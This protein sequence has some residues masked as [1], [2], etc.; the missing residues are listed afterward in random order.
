MDVLARASGELA[1]AIATYPR[2]KDVDDGFQPGKPQLD[3]TVTDAGKSLGLSA[4]MIARQVRN[5]FYGAEA[6]R[7]QRGKSGSWSGCRKK[8]GRPS[9]PSAT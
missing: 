2:V 1:E 7:Q 6:L 8:T 4:A 3:F 5:S 9:R